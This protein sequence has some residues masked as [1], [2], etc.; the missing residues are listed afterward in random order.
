MILN[1]IKY[2]AKSEDVQLAT[3]IHLYFSE[4]KSLYF[5]KGLE[6]DFKKENS[7]LAVITEK[8]AYSSYVGGIY[9]YSEGQLEDILEKSNFIQ[10]IVKLPKKEYAYSI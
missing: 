10:E 6:G 8:K 2:F 5:E 4:A 1:E 7:T 3:L 9:V